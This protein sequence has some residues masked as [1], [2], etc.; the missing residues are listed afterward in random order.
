MVGPN[1]PFA[2]QFPNDV[3]YALQFFDRWNIDS[4]NPK[5][6]WLPRLHSFVRVVSRWGVPD[7]CSFVRPDLRRSIKVTMQ[8]PLGTWNQ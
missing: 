7:N 2:D 4:Y 1:R 6:G 3:I 5:L 8:V